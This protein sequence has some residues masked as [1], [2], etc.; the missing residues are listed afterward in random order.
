MPRHNSCPFTVRP[1][2]SYHKHGQKFNLI[3]LRLLTSASAEGTNSAQSWSSFMTLS[4]LQMFF[5]VMFKVTK[6]NT[7][8]YSLKTIY[9]FLWL[10]TKLLYYLAG[11]FLPCA[12]NTLSEDY[13]VIVFFCF[14]EMILVGSFFSPDLDYQLEQPCTF[15]DRIND[16]MSLLF[17]L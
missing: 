17:S 11:S 7:W 1:Y 12:S 13:F 4:P 5:M 14:C 3:L 8:S 2:R 15:L 16:T 10:L 6:V 9:K